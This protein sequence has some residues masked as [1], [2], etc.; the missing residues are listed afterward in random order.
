M[1]ARLEQARTGHEQDG[2]DAQH[3]VAFEHLRGLVEEHP[4]LALR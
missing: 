3:P 1:D 2:V 4:R